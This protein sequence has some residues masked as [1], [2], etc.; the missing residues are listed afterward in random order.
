M[1]TVPTPAIYLSLWNRH[2]GG[3]L[4][5]SLLSRRLC[6][7]ARRR[8]EADAVVL[9]ALAVAFNPLFD[10]GAIVGCGVIAHGL[11]IGED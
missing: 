6:R 1:V 10:T 7:C 5:S 9:V 3:I 8:P 2:S 4:A 11:R